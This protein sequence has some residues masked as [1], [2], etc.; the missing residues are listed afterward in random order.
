[1]PELVRSLA[2]DTRHI[3]G[4]VA[5]TDDHGHFLAQV[6]GGVAEIRM[7]VEPAHEFRGRVATRQ[8]LAGDA[9]L[10]IG[11]R[12]AAEDDR[13]VVGAKLI[14]GHVVPDPHIAQKPEVR[15]GGDAVV[16][17]GHILDLV[18]IRRHAPTHQS[19]GRGQPL[20]HVDPDRPVRPLQRL[21][22]IKAARAAAHD[23][24][25]EWIPGTTET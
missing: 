12:A 3:H 2:K 10:A 11:L 5:L 23:R 18:V 25:P 17:P 1:M 7:T 15:V 19:V 8:I 14:H 24:N 13:V 6:K 21:G 9:Q 4:H 22:G 16:D 20:E